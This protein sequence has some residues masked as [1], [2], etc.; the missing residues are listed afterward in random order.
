L[1]RDRPLACIEVRIN[2]KSTW[3]LG[4]ILSLAVGIA[5]HGATFRVETLK[6]GPPA[7]GLSPAVRAQLESTGVRVIRGTKTVYC[8]FWFCKDLVTEEDF[9]PTAQRLYP[10][11]EGQLVGV[12]RYARSGSDFREQEL[13]ED[14]YTLRYALMPV[15]G[16]HVGVF[17]TRDFL[18][19]V[20]ARDDKDPGLFEDLDELNE[21]S[22]DAAQAGHPAMY[23]LTEVLDDVGVAPV[24]RHNEE[25]DWWIVRAGLKTKTGDESQAMIV[26]YVVVGIAEE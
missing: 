12:V 19:L 16:N 6:E 25:S 18:L 7:E 22:M 23:P 9:K 14:T 20:C 11:Q 24:M 3:L 8:D 17:P 15:D 21:R 10:F 13:A 2:M 4:P 5:C 26:E 1:D